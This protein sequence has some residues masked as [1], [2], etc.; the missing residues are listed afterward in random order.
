VEVSPR[1]VFIA[2]TWWTAH[3]AHQAVEALGGQR[4][5]YLIQEYEPFTFPMGSLA[6]LARQSYDFPHFAI[7]STELLR[8]YFR[9]S[10]IGV[11]GAGPEAGEQDSVS[12]DNAITPVGPVTEGEIAGRRPRRLLFYA[13]PEAHAARNMFEVGILALS[14]A[15]ADGAF[16][17]G[18]EFHG[19]GAV[20]EAGWL[21][22][23]GGARMVLRPRQSQREYQEF[24]RGHDVGLSLMYTPHPSLVPIEMASAGMLV[25]TNSFENKSDA[26][27]RAVSS[28]LIVTA[29]TVERVAAGLRRAE[30]EADDYARRASGSKVAWCTS[31]D[32][33]FDARIMSRIH[34]FLAAGERRTA[35]P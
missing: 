9:R 31:W 24:L 23:G 33:S 2:T 29:P 14:R 3:I 12:F 28:N 11:F 32:C 20:S 13:R 27:L 34:E 15:I 18:W 7:F 5:L 30:A 16:Q 4:F 26:A 8:D 10:G 25:V 35:L 1:D 6:A 19:L 17:D 21:P 22:L